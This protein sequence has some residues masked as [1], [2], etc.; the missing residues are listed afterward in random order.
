MPLSHY[1]EKARWAL[2]RVAL[3]YREEPHAPLLHRLATKRNERGTVPVLVHA[4]SRY[5]DST[6]I[7]KHIDIVCG[8]DQLF[9]RDVELRREVEELEE[10][11]DKELGP[12]TRRWAYGQALP[13]TRSMRSLWSRDVPPLEASVIRVITPM[14]RRLARMAYKITPENAQRSLERVRGVFRQV[15]DL[16][17]DGRQFLAGDRFTAA[18]L[19]F[20]T[21]AAP[22]L[23]PAECRAVQPALEDVPAAMRDEILRFRETD[24]GR[25]ALRMFSQ[26]RDGRVSAASLASAQ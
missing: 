5:S 15:D 1:R 20:A 10:R 19:T 3:P 16:L 26:Q 6:D 24:A 22:V 9:P 7:L 14:V 23:L 4:G 11:F 25:F 13:Q 8:G 21:L 12:H 17:R 2:D 18:D